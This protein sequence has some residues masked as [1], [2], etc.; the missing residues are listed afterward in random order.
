MHLLGKC[1]LSAY[2]GPGIF[3]GA[4]NVAANEEQKNLAT[5]CSFSVGAGQP[6]AKGQTEEMAY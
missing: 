3:L 5:R 6:A 4:R 2:N 1:L